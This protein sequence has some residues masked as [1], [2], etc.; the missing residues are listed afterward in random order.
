MFASLKDREVL[1]MTDITPAG[2]R[3]PRG[4]STVTGVAIA[5]VPTALWPSFDS[6]T[7][8]GCECSYGETTHLYDVYDD[9]MHSWIVVRANG[10]TFR[11]KTEFLQQAIQLA[12]LVHRFPTY[13]ERS[14]GLLAALVQDHEHDIV[15][16]APW[17]LE[18]IEGERLGHP[19]SN[20]SPQ[21]AP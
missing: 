17:L 4:P 3:V 13:R 16:A 18:L 12:E 20:V 15:D 8:F 10:Q 2:F 1:L 5:M 11:T 21:R 14:G 9:P 19:A 7:F 6:I